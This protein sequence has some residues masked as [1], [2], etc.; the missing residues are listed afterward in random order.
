[1]KKT[2]WVE[3]AGPRFVWVQ[4]QAHVDV[5][6]DEIVLDPDKAEEPYNAPKS[7]HHATLL[8]DLANLR[9][10][11]LQDPAAFARRH[12]ML[13]SGP[14]EIREGLGRESLSQW[15]DIGEMLHTTVGFYVALKKA[16]DETNGETA[17]PVR[18]YLRVFRDAGLFEGAIPEYDDVLLKCAS[19]QLAWLITG[20]LVHCEQT[21]VAAAGYDKDGMEAGP[22]GDFRYH[23]KPTNLIGA[24]YEQLSRLVVSRTEVRVCKGCGRWFPPKHGSQWHHT[25][26][27]GGKKRQ[28]KFR[29][30]QRRKAG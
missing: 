26:G 27:C 7:K 22:A 21:L 1:M 4:G 10:F 23:T 29:E 13:F 2:E 12:G 19:V 18:E 15:R 17:K 11:E 24:A 3:E 5:D 9:D 30:E 8:Y 6:K 16:V 25:E 28:R 20:G 14:D